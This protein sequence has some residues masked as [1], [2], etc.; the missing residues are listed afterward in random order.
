MITCT[1]VKVPSIAS[2]IFVFEISRLTSIFRGAF[3]ET[4]EN[5]ARTLQ[6]VT[7]SLIIKC[8]PYINSISRG[9]HQ[10]E[11]DTPCKERRSRVILPVCAA[12][13]AILKQSAPRWSLR[14]SLPKM[15]LACAIV[16]SRRV[17][18]RVVN[19]TRCNFVLFS[20][21]DKRK[22]GIDR[23]VIYLSVKVS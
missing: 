20:V 18:E 5:C 7:R 22:A 8:V 10:S 2:P 4:C 21:S 14:A 16:P 6:V 1:R 17:R 12:N 23:R 3:A 13:I 19:R 15:N 9:Q 11:R